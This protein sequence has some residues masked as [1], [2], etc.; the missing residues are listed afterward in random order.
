MRTRRRQP[1][2][3]GGRLIAH[4]VRVTVAQ[5]AAL[6]R[7]AAEQRVTV[8]RLLVESTLGGR[9]KATAVE[10]AALQDRL[11]AIERH[12]VG[13]GTNANQM[14]RVA[15]ATGQTP[16]VEAVEGLARWAARALEELGAIRR[17]FRA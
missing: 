6:L 11:Q 13:V 8:P 15:N 10:L 12:V 14:A 2:E 4:K 1:N 7:L 9:S 3:P 17:E 16:T 5:E